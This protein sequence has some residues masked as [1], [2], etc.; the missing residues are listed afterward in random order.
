MFLFSICTI[1]NVILSTVK[2][3]I[4]IKGG[5]L[6]AALTNAITYGF[7]TYVIILTN[8][9][10]LSTGIKMLITAAANFIGVFLVKYFEEK[11]RKDKLWKVEA[12]IPHNEQLLTEARVRFK[13][14]NIPFNYIDIE[15]YY[16]I[17]C[18]CASQSQSGTAKL[19]LDDIHAKYFVS[20]T[21]IL[22]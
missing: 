21:K 11:R 9:A 15:K 6:A 10:G 2:S 3:I 18:F 19:I 7:Y 13:M 16:I 8:D 14:A 22:T 5:K 4:T 12:T 1:I 17:N 20:E